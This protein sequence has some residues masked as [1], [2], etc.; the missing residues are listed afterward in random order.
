MNT[1]KI[2]YNLNRPCVALLEERMREVK[3][4]ERALFSYNYCPPPPPSQSMASS[5]IVPG[6]I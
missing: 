1:F 6:N 5:A 4:I 2:H 3:L